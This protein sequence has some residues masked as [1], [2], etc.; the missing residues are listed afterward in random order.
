MPWDGERMLTEAHESGASL[1]GWR[2]SQ[3][4]QS[5]SAYLYDVSSELGTRQHILFFCEE[6]FVLV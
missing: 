6:V 1:V 2:A 3:F 4:D 5:E